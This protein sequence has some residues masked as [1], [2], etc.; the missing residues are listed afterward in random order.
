MLINFASLKQNFAAQN[1]RAPLSAAVLEAESSDDAVPR[2]SQSK[3]PVVK[4]FTDA[5]CIK[6]EYIWFP[7]NSV[8]RRETRLRVSIKRS[9]REFRRCCTD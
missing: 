5:Y 6:G 2:N 4:T 1:K 7:V 8:V 9:R 3:L